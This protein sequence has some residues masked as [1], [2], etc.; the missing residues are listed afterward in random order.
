VWVQCPPEKLKDAEAI[1][2]RAGAVE[3]R[4]ER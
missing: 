1:M 3:V 2:Q 4:G